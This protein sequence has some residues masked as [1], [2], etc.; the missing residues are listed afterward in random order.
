MTGNNNVVI[1]LD[2]M[3]DDDFSGT[4]P[5]KLYEEYELW[6]EENGMNVQSKKQFNDAVGKSLT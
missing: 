6:A 1:Y 2:D 3:T 4:Q 5:P